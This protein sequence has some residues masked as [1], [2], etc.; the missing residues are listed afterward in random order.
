MSGNWRRC[1]L[2]SMAVFAIAVALVV[3]VIGFGSHDV[4]AALP[5]ID[6]EV[7]SPPVSESPVPPGT[8]AS[9]DVDAASVAATAN[10]PRLAFAG[11]TWALLG[12]WALLLVILSVAMFVSI[13]RQEHERPS[14]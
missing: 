7:V 12:L 8:S 1:V 13:R 14:A 2:V 9:P 11:A 4:L 5:A 10:P 6:A 3:T